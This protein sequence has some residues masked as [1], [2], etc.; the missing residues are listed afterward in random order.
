MVLLYTRSKLAFTRNLLKCTRFQEKIM[1]CS[2]F[3]ASRLSTMWHWHCI[4]DV[5]YPRGWVNGLVCSGHCTASPTRNGRVHSL[6]EGWL[7]SSSQ[8]TR[9]H[10][11]DRTYCLIFALQ[12]Y[13]SDKFEFVFFTGWM[14]FLTPV[15]K[16]WKNANM[17]YKVTQKDVFLKM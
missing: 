4:V 7:G 9:W 17:Q 14:L 15:S 2:K 10:R 8:I 3:A 1:C 12:V 13:M 11:G 16:H 6:R 5:S